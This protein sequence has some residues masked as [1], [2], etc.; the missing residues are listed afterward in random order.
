MSLSISVNISGDK[1]KIAG[2]KKLGQSLTMLQGAMNTIGKSLTDYS[3]TKV[4][5]SRGG[6]LGDTWD[7]LSPAYKLLKAK[8]YPGRSPLVKTGHMQRS[9]AH[10]AD[11]TSVTIFNEAEYFAYH[12]SN[13]PRSHLPR[14]A[15][16]AVNNDIRTMVADIINYDINEKIRKA[17]L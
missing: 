11:D 3:S 10:E 12:Q 8:Q 15:M 17:G 14:R 9:F 7:D 1:E 13:E 6:I 5:A 2:L 16:M 4:F